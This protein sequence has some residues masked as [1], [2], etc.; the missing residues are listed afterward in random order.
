MKTPAQISPASFGTTATQGTSVA[1]GGGAGVYTATKVQMVA[2][3]TED[4][5]G[6]WAM[7][8]EGTTIGSLWKIY[9]GASGSEVELTE[10]VGTN[11]PTE[12]MAVFLPIFIPAGSRVSVAKADAD[13]FGSTARIHLV[14]VRSR[15]DGPLVSRGRLIGGGSGALTDIDA[16]ATANTKGAWV[17][18]SASTPQDARGFTLVGYGDASSDTD[19]RHFFDVGVGGAGSEQII[20]ADAVTAQEGF[21]VGLRG[22]PI[23]PI[24]TPIPAGSRIAVRAQC[25]S[26]TTANRVP[27][28]AMILWE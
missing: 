27:R 12:P 16:G 3:T 7:T 28:I 15:S 22:L 18:L 21:R 8:S 14:P 6:V 17:Q 13:G 9:V 23:G 25:S 2:S 20:L 19:V 10:F 1:G 11:G 26:N 24:W 5:H 4:W